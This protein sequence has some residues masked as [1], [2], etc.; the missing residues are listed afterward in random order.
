MILGKMT[1]V[2]EIVH[3]NDFRCSDCVKFFNEEEIR[4][5]QDTG[6]SRRSHL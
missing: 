2:G 3:A 5:D 4:E 6:K 1:D